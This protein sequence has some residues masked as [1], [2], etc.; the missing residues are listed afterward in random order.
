MNIQITKKRAT[1]FALLL[2]L[3]GVWFLIGWIV[4]GAWD[5]SR[6]AKVEAEIA[7]I[8]QVRQRLLSEHPDRPLTTRELTH[9]AIRGMLRHTGDPY[10]A[11]LEPPVARRFWDDFAGESGIVGLHLEQECG[12]LRVGGLSPGGPDRKSVV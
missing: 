4:R 8:E 11:L 3:C 9:G 6:I 1:N 12:Q 2:V 10:A 5:A 7:L